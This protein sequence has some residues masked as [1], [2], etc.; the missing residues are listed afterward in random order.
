MATKTSK[1]AAVNPFQ[2]KQTSVKA[3]KNDLLPTP[4][5]IASSIDTF[6]SLSREIKLL[7]GQK[8]S[9]KAELTEY[10]R[11]E[12]AGRKMNGVEG[13]FKVEGVESTASYI[14]QDRSSSLSGQDREAFAE[15]FGEKAAEDLLKVDFAGYRFNGEVLEQ[16][17]GAVIAALQKGLPEDVLAVLIQPTGYVAVPQAHTKIKEHAK[18][19]KDFIEILKALKVVNFIQP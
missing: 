6:T 8:E 14:C 18:T 13:N 15:E 4:P 11:N 12:F 17:F 7:E 16:H 10:C 9:V 3:S 1:T 2:V 5:E 19:R